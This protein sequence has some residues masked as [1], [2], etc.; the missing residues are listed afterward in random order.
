MPLPYYLVSSLFHTSRI[1]QKGQLL[2]HNQPISIQLEERL[3]PASFHVAA[4]PL[5]PQN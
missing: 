5:K 3:S 1:W 4:A 2:L